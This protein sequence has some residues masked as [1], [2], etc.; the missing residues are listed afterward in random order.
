MNGSRRAKFA[1]VVFDAD[2]TLASIEGIDWLGALRGSDI[3]TAIQELTD[4]A[5]AGELALEEVYAARLDIIKPTVE[6]I[7]R[8]ASAY[9]D[10]I[11]PG[12][13]ETVGDLVRAGTNV[14]IVSGGLR[15]AL[16]PL[17]AHLGVPADSVFAVEL[18]H[19][20]DGNYVSLSPEQP[21]SR[22]DGKP[23]VVHALSLPPRI[24]M[25]GDGSTDAAVRDV[26]DIFIAYTHVARRLP[27]VAVAHAEARDFD[28]LRLHLF[29]A[30]T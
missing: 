2:S 30:G 28:E 29:E 27:V 17:A 24:A 26:V 11:E 21:L 19:D 14:V 15:S 5:M 18:I 6:E 22:Q 9:I 7:D 8:L 4:R 13:R 1:S 25:I 3:G 16:L 12:A 20:A 23:R 10:A